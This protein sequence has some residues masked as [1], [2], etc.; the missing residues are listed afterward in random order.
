M[1]VQHPSAAFV[2]IGA[3]G[4]PMAVQLSSEGFETTGVD[5]NP[6]AQQRGG[7]FGLP[8]VGSLSDVDAPDL[9]IVMVATP[10]QLDTLVEDAITHASA[11]S[12][13][14]VIMSTVGRDAIV[15]AG[16]RL[17][18]AGAS[19]VDAPVTGGV[20]RARTGE[21]TIFA[22]GADAAV[23]R[24]R[25]VLDRLGTVHVIGDLPG[26]GQS[27]K[28]INQH[29]CSVHIAVAAEA[30]ALTERLGMDP[31][32]V[33]PLI[34]S[35]AAGSWMLSD[36]GPR[37]LQGTDVEVA[38]QISIFVKDS[39]L[40][41]D[42]ARAVGATTPILDAAKARFDLAAAAGLAARDDSQVIETYR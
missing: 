14:W 20:G 3:I 11:L 28:T 40:V 27:V 24:A 1:T 26:Q 9:V 5:P 25:P 35:G 42:A 39:A 32:A 7:Q 41:A 21:L 34:E 6:T 30:L 8:V 31:H 37:M 33:L 18:A 2:G 13:T 29:L 12:S 17:H 36:R 16:S 38:S 19:V 23:E 10:T 22:S 4:L 15:R